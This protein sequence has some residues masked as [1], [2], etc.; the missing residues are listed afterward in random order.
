[1]A[2]KK[3]EKHL[4]CNFEIEGQGKEK[5]LCIS[6]TEM[7]AYGKSD[8]YK[9]QLCQCREKRKCTDTQ[10]GCCRKRFLEQIKELEI[11]KIILF[12]SEAVKFFYGHLVKTGKIDKWVGQKI[13]DQ[14]FD[15][16][17]YPNYHPVFVHSNKNQKYIEIYDQTIDDIIDHNKPFPQY[18]T[19]EK[20]IKILNEAEAIKFLIKETKKEKSIYI[21]DVETSGLKPHKE[22]HYIKSISFTA[23]NGRTNVFLI[24]EKIKPYLQLFLEKHRFAAQNLPFENKWFRYKL[25]IFVDWYWDTMIGVH[26]LDSRKENKK[27]KLQTLFNFGIAGYDK[28]VDKYLESKQKGCYSFNQ[29]D[30]CPV[31]DLLLYNGFDT[32]FTWLLF[33]KQYPLLKDHEGFQFFMDGIRAICEVE[34]NGIRMDIEQC[35]KNDKILQKKMDILSKKIYESDEV[36]EWY[37]HRDKDFKFTSTKDLPDL[38]FN[39]LKLES[40]KETKTGKPSTDA[41]ALEQVDS[42]F[43]ANILKWK[44]IDK[45]K[46]TYLAGFIRESVETDEDCDWLMFPSFNL[47]TVTTFRS[48]C[49]AKGELVLIPSKFKFHPIGVPIETIKAGDYVYCYNDKLELTIGKVK[50]SGKTGHKKTINIKWSGGQSNKG[51]LRVTPEHLIRHISGK[52]IKAENLLD[53]YREENESRHSPKCRVLSLRRCGDRLYPT[54]Q[55]EQLEHRF[56]YS[57]FTNEI[58]S[59]KDI[60]H[61]KDGDHLNHELSNLE[62]TNH[63]NHA[64][65]H[66]K[67]TLG[68]EQSRKNNMKAVKKKWK[69]KEYPIRTGEECHNYIGLSKQECIDLLH[70][71]KGQIKKVPIGFETFKKYCNM[72]DINIQEIKYLYNNEGLFLSKEIIL[73]NLN[74]Y[75]FSETQNILQIG[76]YKLKKLCKYYNIE[77]ERSFSNQNGYCRKQ[78]VSTNNHVITGID[79]DYK[80]VDVYDIEV[81]DHHNFIVNEI[82]VHNSSNPNFQNI[83]NHNDFAQRMTRGTIIPRK[84]NQIMEVDYSGIEVCISA[85]YNQDPE[86]IRYITDPE[87]DMHRDVASDLYMMDQKDISKD[88]RFFA[89]NG[90]VFPQFYGSWFKPC[91]EEIW[92]NIIKT[93]DL[94]QHMKSVNIGS[95]SKFEK[96]VQKVE[97]I[98]WNERFTAYRDWKNEVWNTYLEK[99]LVETKTGFICKGI[100]K[101][102]EILNYP[103]QGSAFHCLLWSFIEIQKYLKE[104]G[105]KTKIVGQIHDSIIFDIV[106]EEKEIIKKQIRY[107]MTE[108]IKE[109]WKWIIVPLNIEAEI[110]EIDGNWYE[111]KNEEI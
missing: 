22:G 80:E 31:D 17:V 85:C 21:T 79:F 100:F 87:T 63:K 12:G 29:I 2:K 64:S 61:H 19:L 32:Y 25:N 105:F 111:K 39:I 110:T 77:Y 107:I 50:W 94:F 9:L 68:T 46:N 90:F 55:Q 33:K 52:Y 16:W 1:M 36:K 95:Y 84:G 66:Y 67:E 27:L 37:K 62:K 48:S 103:I 58:L 109:H 24:T 104:N 99:G 3:T 41:E 8:F 53:D 56:I 71:A 5:I 78:K 18:K 86:L 108:K 26:I 76:Y 97:D 83:P 34:D 91:A 13:P 35:H 54:N 6:H 106:P 51:T 44:K 75:G 57:Y 60:I 81:E 11:E 93:P 28:N 15:C 45:I 70:K 82:C 74:K 69:N 59:S 20:K 98:F 40:K 102:N 73:N 4:E 10:I 49:V 38:L 65:Y 30:D 14:N 72:Y 101:R 92:G 47:H 96:Q 23:M 43:A 7:K 89:K 42:P 88:F